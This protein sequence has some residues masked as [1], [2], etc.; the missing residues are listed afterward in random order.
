ME[1]QSLLCYTFAAMNSYSF[2][3][4]QQQV[5]MNGIHILLFLCKD[6]NWWWSFLQALQQVHDLG[7]LLHVFHFL[8]T[9]LIPQG[10][11][12]GILHW[13]DQPLIKITFY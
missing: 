3:A 4:L 1:F 9:H 7:L 5:L 6:E 11:D 2:N 12:N 10:P 8:Q 13:C